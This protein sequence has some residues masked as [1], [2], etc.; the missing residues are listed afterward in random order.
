MIWGLGGELAL[1]RLAPHIPDNAHMLRMGNADV[2]ILY[3]L[4]IVLHE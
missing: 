1:L 3:V 2:A 4:N